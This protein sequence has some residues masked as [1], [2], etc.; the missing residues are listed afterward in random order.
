MTWTEMRQQVFAANGDM[1]T[2]RI[3]SR[4]EV[5]NDSEAMQCLQRLCQEQN[6]TLEQIKQ[7]PSAIRNQILR[8]AREQGV[9]M[10]QLS[11]LTGVST[12][13]IARLYI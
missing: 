2:A 13:T 7:T 10:R 12:S 8:A 11:R 5:K 1:N 9:G 6:I 4:Q 3:L